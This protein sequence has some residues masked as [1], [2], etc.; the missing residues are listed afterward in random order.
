MMNMNQFHCFIERLNAEMAFVA[1]QYNHM[2]KVCLCLFVSN[3]CKLFVF[4]FA[5]SVAVD[6]LMN[7]STTKTNRI[8]TA[9]RMSHTFTINILITKKQTV[10]RR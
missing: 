6:L 7:W 4:S 3:I 2:N 9:R 8:S 1:I 10:K 5:A